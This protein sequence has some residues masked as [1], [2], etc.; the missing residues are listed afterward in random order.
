MI[1]YQCD[2]CGTQQ[3]EPLAHPLRTISDMDDDVALGEMR[4]WERPFPQELCHNCSREL[5]Q[6]QDAKKKKA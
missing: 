1:V 2:R 6:W 4:G 5:R 3:H